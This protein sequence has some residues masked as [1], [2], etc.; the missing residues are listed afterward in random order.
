LDVFQTPLDLK[1]LQIKIEVGVTP[2][3]KV[4]ALQN[5]KIKTEATA[6]KSRL[7]LL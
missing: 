5:I 1:Q 3:I 4:E 6:S 2:A 7:R